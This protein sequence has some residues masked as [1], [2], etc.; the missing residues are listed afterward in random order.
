LKNFSV[1]DNN[2]KKIQV[3]NLNNF[4]SEANI[5]HNQ[6]I[7]LGILLG[8]DYCDTIKG[9]GLKSAFKFIKKYGSIENMIENNIIDN[10][11]RCNYVKTREY[12]KNPIVTKIKKKERIQEVNTTELSSFLSK[13]G[14]NSDYLIKIFRKIEL[15]K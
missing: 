8:S 12:F 2:R 3:I 15:I 6:L 7:D 4:L 10:S 1:T 11:Y 9:I 14:Y 13:M 5:T